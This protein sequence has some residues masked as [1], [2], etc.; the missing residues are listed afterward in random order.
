MEK[1]TVS[2]SISKGGIKV[3]ILHVWNTAAVPATLAKY[4]EK[5]GHETAVVFRNYLYQHLFQFPGQAWNCSAK[6]FILKTI[7]QARKYD[8]I[9]V[10]YLDYLCTILKRLYPRKKVVLTYHGSDIRNRYEERKKHFTKADLVCV[11]TPDLVYDDSFVYLP[12]PVD[13]ETFQRV[14]GSVKNTAFF[15]WHDYS[16]NAF[17]IVKRETQKR[18]LRLLILDYPKDIVPYTIFPRVLEIFEY[19]YDVKEQFGRINP[20]MSMT[21]LQA[22]ALGCKVFYLNR[23]HTDFPYE[24]DPFIVAE[25]ALQLYEEVLN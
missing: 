20:A 25:K 12:S 23:Y 11:S 9:H 24:H 5:F 15:L 14:N 8:I 10:H 16:H 13:L 4:Q 2:L 1:N 18:D 17:N 22:L 21:G 6:K 7:L 3:K 19:Y